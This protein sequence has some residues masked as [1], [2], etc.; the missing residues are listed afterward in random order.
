[1]FFRIL[2]LSLAVFALSANR[3]AA[4]SNGLVAASCESMLPGHSTFMPQ[5]SASPYTVSTSMSYYKPG[6]SVTVTLEAA[7]NS[8]AFLGF[9]LQARVIGGRVPVGC[10]TSINSSLYQG[11]DC[12]N[13]P[14]SSVSH[15]SAIEKTQLQVTWEAPL[16]VAPG[17]I[18]FCGTFVKNYQLFW[19]AVNSPPVKMVGVPS[20]FEPGMR[21]DHQH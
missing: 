11:L 19:V 16:N 8:S 5:N 18:M 2:L 20:S 12:N 9:M 6:D 1:M 3:A 17:D 15:Q 10:F 13:S 7:G 14:N 21:P 4:F